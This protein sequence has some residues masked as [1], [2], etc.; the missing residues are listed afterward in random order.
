MTAKTLLRRAG[1]LAGAI[2][3]HPQH[4]VCGVLAAAMIWLL[5]GRLAGGFG[6]HP[7]PSDV[8]S[9]FDTGKRRAAQAID[10]RTIASAHLFGVTGGSSGPGGQGPETSLPLRLV[11]TVAAANASRGLAILAQGEGAVRL[12]SIGDALPGGAVLRQVQNESAVIERAGVLER[13]AF[14]RGSGDALALLRRGAAAMP[15]DDEVDEVARIMV[16]PPASAPVEDYYAEQ[17]SAEA[18]RLAGN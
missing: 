11:G 4:L 2:Q 14:S 15:A 6:A 3:A 7:R 16:H 10:I 17:Q 5:L 13:L 8:P 18:R 9:R 1:E 12:Y